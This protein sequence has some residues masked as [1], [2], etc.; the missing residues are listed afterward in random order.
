M[1]AL[2]GQAI[3]SFLKNPTSNLGSDGALALL[4]Y[5]PDQGLVHER[6]QKVLKVLEK[7]LDDPMATSSF[8]GDELQGDPDRIFIEL[9]TQSLFGGQRIV[10][11]KGDYAQLGPALKGA[12]DVPCANHLI[13]EAGNLT[14]R[15]PLRKLFD[16][17]KHTVSLPCYADSDA[18]IAQL[19]QSEITGHGLTISSD[20]ARLLK[21]NIGSDRAVSRSEIEKLCLYA[22][23]KSQ[24]GPDDVLAVIGDSAMLAI[25][26]LIDATAGGN[27]AQMDIS[28]QRLKRAGNTTST[29]AIMVLNHFARL[30]SMRAAIDGGQPGSQVIKS[31]RPPIFFKR[32]SIIER[33]L[34]L[35]NATALRRANARLN[36]AILEGRQNP[37]LAEASLDHA[38]LA[39][40]AGA[41]RH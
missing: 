24:I 31:A 20:A 23:G 35:W 6:G 25:D 5:G 8:S 28:L 40:C 14:P 1:T 3:G 12:F 33:Q 21:E 4:I 13:I 32:V 18:D 7:Q 38:L 16:A 19:I 9:D 37:D 22:A 29:L 17:G 11:V 10:Y 26:D 39:I 30:E 15:S 34:R 2:K 36:S 27:F 41:A